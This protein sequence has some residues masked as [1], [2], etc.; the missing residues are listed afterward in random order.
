ML[1]FGE[2][3]LEKGTKDDGGG[4]ERT[5][6][7]KILI[8]GE[9][10]LRFAAADVIA[11]FLSLALLGEVVSRLL[12]RPSA[13]R[14][15]RVSESGFP[16]PLDTYYISRFLPPFLPSFSSAVFVPP[17]IEWQF[18]LKGD[19]KRPRCIYTRN[20]THAVCSDE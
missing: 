14:D 7:C 11:F 20:E 4:E 8:S 5:E 13:N 2:N 1:P 9:N 6:K 15:S 16:L 12:R 18:H 19:G 3:W 17:F 10:R